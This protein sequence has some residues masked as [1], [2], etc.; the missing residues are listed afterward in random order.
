MSAKLYVRGL[1]TISFLWGLVFTLVIGFYALLLYFGA[2]GEVL[3]ASTLF[4]WVPIVIAVGIVFVQFLLSPFIMDLMLR[5][6][7][8]M[9]WIKPSQ[10]PPYLATFVEEQS[11]IHG[12]SISKIGMIHDQNP[13]AFTY[14]HFKKN[15]RIVL[16]DG[17]L[18]LLTPEE[19]TAV[20]SHEMGHI[21]HR[22][23]FFMTL[24][25]AVPLVFYMLFVTN[26]TTMRVMVDIS[27][28]SSG[29][30]NSGQAILGIVAAMFLFMI[31]SYLFYIISQF[32][33][34]FLSRVREYYADN[35]SGRNTK[36]PN[37]LST[38]LVKIAYGLVVSD[39]AYS[40][41]ANNKEA[42]HRHRVTYA[43][44]Q[45]FTNATRSL[46]IFDV[47]AAK[48]LVMTAYAQTTTTEISPKDIARAAAW[49]F[50]SP[51]AMFLELQSTHPLVA[52]RIRAMD[53][54]NEEMYK[55]RDFPE[56][57]H[58]LIEES[59]WPEFFEDLFLRNVVPL[60]MIGL[61]IVGLISFFFGIDIRFGIASGLTLAA[62]LWIWRIKI[63]YPK[64]E[65]DTQ[66]I[67]IID[68]VTD[69]SND[70][71]AEA[72]PFRGKVIKLRGTI[73]GKGQAGYHFSEDMVL[74]DPSGIITLDYHPV[75]G[76]LRLWAALF[77]VNRW[78]GTQVEV[79]GWFRRS[80][81]PVVLVKRLTRQDGGK[82]RTFRDTVNW[83]LVGI[84]FFAAFLLI[85][86]TI[87]LPI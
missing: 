43:K 69:V 15:A 35:F 72:S 65:E 54:L 40:S 41:E 61:P 34:L 27:A 52:K 37:A 60:L 80:P 53:E 13:T 49:D 68:A 3:A 4:T 20:V 51:W 5:W 56:L 38:A 77:R 30:K 63:R 1:I 48:G 11:K 86:S 46:N 26:R 17:I 22:D 45:G 84:Y 83:V 19:Q 47:T 31:L 12:I 55:K 39:A 75:I 87:P 16:S 44:R 81:Y 23:F 74:R 10:L 59:L 14:G 78:I 85:L 70:G 32:I 67:N 6:V 24:A 2:T 66:A 50:E 36:K 21:A 29:N 33:V 62:F 57:G 25:S 8:N 7:Y 76:I 64:I 28:R 42:S 18:T 79:V 82:M 9:T 58:D 73:I 71:Y